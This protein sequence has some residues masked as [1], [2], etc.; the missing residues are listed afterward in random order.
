VCVCVGE[1]YSLSLKFVSLR[2]AHWRKHWNLVR[3]AAE[4]IH[5]RKK[6]ESDNAGLWV[7]SPE[8]RELGSR[9]PGWMGVLTSLLILSIA[10][11]VNTEND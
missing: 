9:H 2:R 1:S 7:G 8:Y 4:A 3:E 10:A 11:G 5:H 6:C